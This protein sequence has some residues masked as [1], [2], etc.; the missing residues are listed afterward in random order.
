MEWAVE[1]EWIATNGVGGYAA[2]TVS[3]CNTRRYHALLV[4]NVPGYG[5]M[6]MLPFLREEVIAG[7]QHFRA[8]GQE[9]PDGTINLD[10][11]KY[12]RAFRLVGLIPEWEFQAGDL[13]LRRR[14][15]L[16]HGE[17]TVVVTY[18]HLGGIPVLIRLRPFPH[19]R[20]HDEKLSDVVDVPSVWLKRDRVEVHS[21][22]AAHALRFRLHYTHCDTPF[23]GITE[24]LS[25]LYRLERDRGYEYTEQLV[26]PGYFESTLAEGESLALVATTEGWASADRDPLAAFELEQTREERLLDRARC[27][28]RQDEVARLVLAADQFLFEPVGRPQDVV[29]MKA[30]GQLA[31][32]VIA[33]YHWFGD[34]GRDTMISLE[35]LTLATGRYDEAAAILSIFRH[36]VRDG[37]IPNLF[38]EGKAEGLY[39]T[40]DATLWY[41]HAIDRYVSYT[42]DEELLWDLWP[43]LEDIVQR[44]LNGTRFGISVDA[45]DGLLRQGAADVPLTWMDA[46]MNDWIVTPR[47]GKAVEINGLWFNA[48]ML[49]ADWCER[50][51]LSPSFYRDHAAKAFESFQRR[52]WNPATS[53]LFDVVDG[54]N[55]DDPAIRP[56]QLF[57]FSLRHPVL[58]EERRACVLDVVERELLT[59]HGL[60][61]LSPGHPDYRPKYDGAR[62]ARDG[63]YHQGTIWPWLAGHYL[64]AVLRVRRKTSQ[65]EEDVVRAAAAGLNDCCIGQIS[66]I[67]DAE[68]PF[69]SRGCVAQAWSVAEVLRSLRRLRHLRGENDQQ[70]E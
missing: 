22:D 23:V 14:V 11:L 51:G 61:T 63:A 9:F 69:R 7:D 59:T 35:G 20:P 52:F 58:H 13:R 16:V 24:R 26:S 48:L 46:W 17:N 53:C 44:H 37:M 30:T 36:Y 40:A 47:R 29:L 38:P 4:A 18:E 1:K 43:T 25:L 50:F 68:P 34:W 33:G 54:D 65:L 39:H 42:D 67:F 62:R 8:G 19:F 27:E 10:G 57:S 12:L 45:S 32:S 3:G 60:R 55:G 5:R 66:E 15:V 64:N 2:G 56:N 49:M 28:T 6:V 41:F 31:R 70:G 21:G